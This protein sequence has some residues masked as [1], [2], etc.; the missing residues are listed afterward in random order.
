MNQLEAK[1]SRLLMN[2]RLLD[3]VLLVLMSL[4]SNKERFSIEGRWGALE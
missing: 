4:N 2:Q 1:N 3:M